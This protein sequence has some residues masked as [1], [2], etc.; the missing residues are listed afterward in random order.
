MSENR[1]TTVARIRTRSPSAIVAVAGYTAAISMTKPPTQHAAAARCRVED[2]RFKM[3]GAV[4]AACPDNP[5]VTSSPTPRITPNTTY[6]GR[7]EPRSSPRWE[8][9][10]AVVLLRDR[11]PEDGHDGKQP[12]SRHRNDPEASGSDANEGSQGESRRGIV[13]GPGTHEDGAEAPEHGSQPR[14]E[15][16]R[17]RP[18][19]E[20][21]PHVREGGIVT[22]RGL[23]HDRDEDDATHHEEQGD[24]CRPPDDDGRGTRKIC[25]SEAREELNG[26]SEDHPH[27]EQATSG[28]SQ[29]RVEREKGRDGRPRGGQSTA[30]SG[31]GNPL[32][33]PIPPRTENGVRLGPGTLTI[34]AQRHRRQLTAPSSEPA[35][36][37]PFQP[38]KAASTSPFSRSGTLK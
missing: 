6:A 19:C 7:A 30:T 33:V 28:R 5:G 13:T 25:P 32:A 16:D 23:P 2:E 31:I 9:L 14:P 11:S 36:T 34:G 24:R 18:S 26:E 8:R 12:N 35:V 27:T 38:T 3:T 29:L 20:P 4:L 22:H 1:D 37:S 10:L 15:A 17:T 21:C